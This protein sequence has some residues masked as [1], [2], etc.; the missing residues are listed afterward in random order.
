[1]SYFM[2][3]LKSG[4]ADDKVAEDNGDAL[5]NKPG[6]ADRYVRAV[7][8]SISAQAA[9]YFNSNGETGGKVTYPK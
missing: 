3:I 4:S 6:R 9:E 7:P 8:I 5:L 1:M 2:L